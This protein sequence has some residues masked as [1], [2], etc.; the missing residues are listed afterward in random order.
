M[1]R[2]HVRSSSHHESNRYH[3]TGRPFARELAGESSGWPI[4][5][6]ARIT[7][8]LLAVMLLLLRLDVKALRDVAVC[9]EQL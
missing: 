7:L 1:C 5:L 3:Q 8:C 9:S 6:I 4:W 2:Q